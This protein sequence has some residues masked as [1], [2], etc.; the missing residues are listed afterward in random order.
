MIF[1][2]WERVEGQE[3]VSSPVRSAFIRS[4]GRSRSGLTNQLRSD[5]VFERSHDSRT[6]FRHEREGRDRNRE[7]TKRISALSSPD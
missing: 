4:R 1:C 5:C 6:R 7:R 3:K 2:G